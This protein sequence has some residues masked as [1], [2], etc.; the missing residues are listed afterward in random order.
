MCVAAIAEMLSKELRTA[1]QGCFFT[2]VLRTRE[3]AGLVPVSA[4]Q[5]EE[6][7][8]DQAQQPVAPVTDAA[9]LMLHARCAHVSSS[10]LVHAFSRYQSTVFFTFD[11]T[12][13]ARTFLSSPLSKLQVLFGG[14][15]KFSQ[16]MTSVTKVYCAAPV[17][18]QHHVMGHLPCTPVR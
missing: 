2:F 18:I 5:S 11:C 8:Q 6:E 15:S 3:A 13:H 14:Q 10:L 9:L 17:Y 1:L 4:A 7:Q 16:S 12:L